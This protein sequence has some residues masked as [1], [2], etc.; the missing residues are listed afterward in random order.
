MKRSIPVKTVIVSMN[1]KVRR[2]N[3]KRAQNPLKDYRDTLYQLRQTAEESVLERL[4]DLLARY[5]EYAENKYQAYL[6]QFP[7]HSL[8]CEKRCCQ[9]SFKSYHN[10]LKREL[11]WNKKGTHLLRG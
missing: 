10:F 1:I 7:K 8:L 9:R 4:R 3:G 6:K 2:S 11:R 5:E